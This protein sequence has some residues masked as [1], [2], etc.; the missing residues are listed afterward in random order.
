MAVQH[1]V[2]NQQLQLFGIV[3]TPSNP[4][5]SYLLICGDVAQV[6]AW[7]GDN[8]TDSDHVTDLPYV[9]LEGSDYLPE[10]YYGRFSATNTTELTTMI[11]KTLMYERYEMPDPSYLERATLIAGVDDDW[12][13]T[14]GNGTLNYGSQY[15]FNSAHAIDATTYPYPESGSSESSIFADINAGLGYLNYTAHGSGIA[16][17]DPAFSISDVNNLTNVQQYPVV[18]GNCCLTNHFDTS[19]C[20]GEA[21]LRASNGAVIYIG[22]TNS[23]YWDEDYWWSG[24]TFHANFNS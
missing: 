3:A 18:V 12:A 4:A 24:R 8:D 15:Y 5:P 6:P 11:N 9:K 19:T 20:F 10:M 13:P 7:D 21:W 22:G 17:Y 1:P 23:T 14:H 2:F 16:W